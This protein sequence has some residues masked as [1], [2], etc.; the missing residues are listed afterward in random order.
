MNKG[1]Y[2]VFVMVVNFILENWEP[3][4]VIIHLFE[5]YNTIG[6]IMAFQL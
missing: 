2:D 3:K 1:T 4:H 5:P 6:A